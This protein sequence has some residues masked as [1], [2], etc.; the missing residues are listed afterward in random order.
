MTQA[1]WRC[2]PTLH[3]QPTARVCRPRVL[4]H[5]PFPL[6]GQLAKNLNPPLAA[7]REEFGCDQSIVYA[8]VLSTVERREERFVQRGSGPNW[9]G[10]CL[11]LCTCKHFLRTFREP[12]AWR[13]VW[14]AGFSGSRADGTRN[15]L[16]YLSR[17][18]HAFASQ[19]EAWAP[20]ALSSR[21][22]QAK[23]AHRHRFGDLFAPVAPHGNPFDPSHYHRPCPG[24]VHEP[25]NGWHGDINYV[26][27]NGRSAALLACDPAQTFLRERPR[28]YF[29]HRLGRGQRKD[30]LRSLL[31]VLH[32][33]S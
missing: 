28:I 16:I 19:A 24:H 6:T 14:L 23:A 9:Q 13:G 8:Y 33:A 5:Q 2:R 31:G 15:A 21:T 22:K 20:D 30:D 27:R 18:E 10:D 7:L 25:W 12:S 3:R 29:P 32:E 26:G 1:V 11:T 17:V 4:D